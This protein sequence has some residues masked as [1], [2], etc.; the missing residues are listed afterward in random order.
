MQNHMGYEEEREALLELLEYGANILEAGELVPMNNPPTARVEALRNME[1][2]DLEKAEDLL[3]LLYTS[4][5]WVCHKRCHRGKGIELRG[6][7][8]VLMEAQGKCC[9]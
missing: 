9:A 2:P 1:H 3:C 8:R 7:Q 6:V 4:K 5:Q